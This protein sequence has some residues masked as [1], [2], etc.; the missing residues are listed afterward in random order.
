M[1]Q[2]DTWEREY[3]DSKLVTKDDK[4]GADF[5]RFLKFLKKERGVVLENLHLIDIGC[6]TG[7]NSNYFAGLENK[8]TGIDIS[9]TAITLAQE[10]AKREG[11]DVEYKEQDIGSN[12]PYEENFFDI[13][14]DITSS[15]SL[16]EAGREMYL[17]ETKRVLKPEGYFFVKALCKEGDHNAKNLLK[18][19]PGKEKDTYFMKDLGLTERVWEK[20]DFVQIYSQYFNIF[21]LEKK[22][23]YTRLNNRVYKRNFWIAYMQKK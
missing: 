10:R 9:H 3:R 5:V 15:N 16:D 20:E 1:P 19:S 17:K 6:G 8:V 11:L 7:K 23:S 12:Y 18:E 4:P 2:K 21:H 22:T 13:A 14:I